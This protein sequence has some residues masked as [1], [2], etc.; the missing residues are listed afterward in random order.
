MISIEQIIEQVYYEFTND[1]SAESIPTRN[2]IKSVLEETEIERLLTTPGIV[3]PDHELLLKK[4][5]VR[6]RKWHRDNREN[7]RLFEYTRNLLPGVNGWIADNSSGKSSIL[8][9][10]VWAISGEKPQFKADVESWIDMV[11]V[12]LEVANSGTFTIQ[13]M[14]QVTGQ[15]VSGAIYENDIDSVLRG[16]PNVKIVSQF[17]NR[18]DM[19][20]CL[21]EFLGTFIG[22]YKGFANTINEFDLHKNKSEWNAYSLAMFIGADRYDDYLFP[23]SYGFGK[24]HQEILGIYLKLDNFTKTIAHLRKSHEALERVYQSEKNYVAR[25]ATEIKGKIEGLVKEK[26]EIE[27]RLVELEM[28][29]S[30]RIDP[31]YART[32]HERVAEAQE[33]LFISRQNESE[34]SHKLR[35]IKEERYQKLKIKQHLVESIEVKLFL[36]H[37]KVTRCPHCTNEISPEALEKELET[38]ICGVC[39]TQLKPLSSE[40]MMEQQRKL[41][42]ELEAGIKEFDKEIRET[43]KE[44]KIVQAQTAHL[45]EGYQAI[46]AEYKSLARQTREGIGSKIR[47]LIEQKGYL[48]GRLKEL[49][50]QSV[51]NQTQR[52]AELK[53]RRDVI[54]SAIGVLQIAMKRQNRET[55]EQ[56]SAVALNYCRRFGIQNLESI[57]ITD[58]FDLQIKQSGRIHDFRDMEASE[59]LR[60]KIAFHLALLILRF[61]DGIGRHPGLLMID[62]P[63]GAEMNDSR[64]TEILSHVAEVARQFNNRIQILV[65]ST[66]EELSS[67]FDDVENRVERRKSGEPLF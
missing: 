36:T 55:L 17:N 25:N 57:I 9:M 20:R 65:A 18:D 8:K 14:P 50:E 2:V 66:R 22:L 5:Y 27:T 63:G 41:L 59:A 37:L 39:H 26:E 48:D 29:Q 54:K 64:L 3:I 24:R 53:L 60:I 4:I 19:A 15:Q 56:L 47:D 34:L 33:Q 43:N 62:A 6:G 23:Y 51:E 44:I 61:R 30:V 28:E 7:D 40:Q 42:S 16:T 49:Q 31:D 52:L 58:Q 38:K 13:Y 10:I 67:I 32:I 46:F 45:E 21:D 11:A 12:E 35:E 1:S